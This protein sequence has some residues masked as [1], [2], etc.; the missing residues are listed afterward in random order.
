M[1]HRRLIT[2]GIKYYLTLPH[3]T[4][5]GI[6]SPSLFRLIHEVFARDI[7][8]DNLNKIDNY[9]QSLIS[10][11]A[12]INVQDLGAKGNQTFKQKKICSIATRES[13][14]AHYGRLLYNLVAEFR[15]QTILELG[16]SLGVGTLHMALA[17]PDAK[18]FTLEGSTEKSGLASSMLQQYV[19]NVNVITGDFND[20]LSN[21]LEA[22]GKIDLAFID[23]N[24]KKE[25]TLK[26]FEEILVYSDNNTVIIFD[27]INWSPGMTDAWS[28][29]QKHEKARVCL[30]LFRMGIVLMDRKLQKESFTIF[31]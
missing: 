16:T 5:H 3:N 25:S 26:Y 4:G 11:Q 21:V 31:Y 29:I 1:I 2:K 15:P 7:D 14:P 19:A 6:H 23:G 13:T 9:R 18:I 17:N 12:K 10:N 27:D 30:D 22:A 28:E 20:R 24:H 8:A